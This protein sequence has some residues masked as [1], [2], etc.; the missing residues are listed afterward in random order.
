MRE[1][2]YTHK[3]YK[4]Y[5]PQHKD[6]GPKGFRLGGDWE[7]RP[8]DDVF[9]TDRNI[10]IIG[11]ELNVELCALQRWINYSAMY[12]DISLSPEFHITGDLIRGH[13][14]Y[15]QGG[16]Y[17]PLFRI[18]FVQRFFDAITKR[19]HDWYQINDSGQLTECFRSIMFPSNTGVYLDEGESLYM[20]TQVIG[21]VTAAAHCTVFYVLNGETDLERAKRVATLTT[22]EEALTQSR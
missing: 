6:F 5:R 7:D 12:A 17:I 16:W 19:P 4:I 21:H 22:W 8:C 9:T 3:L 2:I 15:I 13:A 11:L 18:S 14:C 10:I 1:R 20:H